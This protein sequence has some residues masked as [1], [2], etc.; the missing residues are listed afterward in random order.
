NSMFS[1]M[2]AY[3]IAK[4]AP[5]KISP[6]YFHALF[7]LNLPKPINFFFLASLMMYFLLMVI[8]LNP[9]I[10]IMGALCYAY[11]TYDPIIVAVG[12]DTKMT[13]LGYAPAV[14]AGL[15]LIFQRKYLSG[16]VLLALFAALMTAFNHIQI[17]YYVLWMALAIAIAFAIDR[18][19]KG[20]WKHVVISGLLATL[21][22]GIALG[23]NTA[24]LWPTNEYAKETMRGGRSELT[25]TGNQANKTKGGL[26]KDYAFRWS[27]GI[28]ETLTVLVPGIFGGGSAGVQLESGKSKFAEKLS[29]VG[30]PEEN[31]LQYANAYAYW[32][33]QPG[34]SG[35]VYLGAIICFLAILS[36]ILVEGWLK[37]GLV[38]VCIFSILLSWGSNLPAFN[39]FLFDHLPLYNKFRAP[40]MSLVVPQLGFVVLACMAA[41]V[42]L[43]GNTNRELL[44]KNFRLGT[45][46]TGALIVL[47][48]IMY[49]S[50]DYTGKNDAA[51]KQNFASAMMQQQGGAQPNPQMQQQAEEVT[52]AMMQGLEDDRQMLYGKDLL[53][54]LFFILVAAGAIALFLRNK[55]SRTITLSVL[56]VFSSIDLLAVGGRYLNSNNF[57]EPAEFESV[58]TATQ[59]DLAIKADPDKH[60]RVFDQSVGSPF[61]DSRASYMHNSIGG[62]HPAKL[63]L[64]Q[65]IIERQLSTG[66]MNVFNMLNTKYFIVSNP[67]TRQPEAQRNPGAL[68]NAWF[69]KGIRFAKNADD[70][71]N[72]L[73][74]LN[75]K[76]TA[77]I[78]QRF[79]SVAGD[80]PAFDSAGTIRLIENLNDKITYESNASTPQFAVFSEV[81]FPDGWDVFVDGKKAA[82]CK[83][84]YVLRGMPVP[85]GKHSIE[86]RFEPRS[87]VI[88]NQVSKWFTVLLYLMVAG[89]IVW[90]VRKRRIGETTTDTK[91]AATKTGV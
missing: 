41:N 63:A 66:N 4:E 58:F 1:G 85:A 91:V 13:S 90:E 8:R 49:V 62:Y 61:E 87:V 32:G 35:P 79:R 40:S 33:D 18:G 39:Y 83:V 68:G 59:A 67:G 36:L 42:I 74:T 3:Q 29:E 75:T 89:A 88:G 10:G 14:L 15:L 38:G 77:V 84:N 46:I 17:M 7:T 5:S 54:S 6:D 19:K 73:T 72:I 20:E 70:E 21:A 31:G 11:S 43:F 2:P 45:Y 69:V 81:Y 80:Q 9:W 55:L 52:R 37:W 51:I 50:F 56:V 28:S 71:M 25:A 86:F 64:Y 30:I 47:L 82:Y 24:S 65:D 26:D 44:W 57:V 22:G 27:Y 34:T 53:R 16:T 48:A 23:I 78:D 60:F 12:H 76:D